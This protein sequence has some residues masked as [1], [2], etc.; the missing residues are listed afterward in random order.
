MS[1]AVGNS[2]AAENVAALQSQQKPDTIQTVHIEQP[3]EV[4]QKKQAMRYFI[5]GAN[6]LLGHAMFEEL[7]NDH[8]AI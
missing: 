8:I 6:S 4:S 1:G 2:R 7:R 3:T 5:S